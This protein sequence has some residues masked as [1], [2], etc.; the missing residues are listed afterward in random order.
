VWFSQTHLLLF[1]LLAPIRLTAILYVVLLAVFQGSYRYGVV[2]FGVGFALITLCSQL[3]VV[4]MAVRF[5]TV[6]R[7]GWLVLWPPF[8]LLLQFFSLEAILS[9][10]A[11]PVR[12]LSGPAPAITQPV[13]H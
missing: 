2:I 1:K 7:L 9:L 8:V 3:L 12:L 6:D 10:P 13:V 4:A 11:R 5:K